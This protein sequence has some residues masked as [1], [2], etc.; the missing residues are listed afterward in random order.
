MYS[1]HVTGLKRFFRDL[2]PET[3]QKQHIDCCHRAR[4]LHVFTSN[5]KIDVGGYLLASIFTWVE[6][7]VPR[8][9]YVKVGESSFSLILSISIFSSVCKPTLSFSA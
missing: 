9:R 5:L 6:C 8:I 7:C 1:T 2:I 3:C 4:I